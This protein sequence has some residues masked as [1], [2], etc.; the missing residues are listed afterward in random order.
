[1]ERGGEAERERKRER[2]MRGERRIKKRDGRETP[3]DVSQT[4][5]GQ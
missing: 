3:S 1:M 2:R 4:A 5:G